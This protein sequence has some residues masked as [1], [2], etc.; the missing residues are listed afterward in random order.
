MWISTKEKLPDMC[1]FVLV[2]D[3][4]T[5]EC[6]FACLREEGEELR[7]YATEPEFAMDIWWNFEEFTHWSPVQDLPT[8][9]AEES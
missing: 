5:N 8:T 4:R 3:D 9:E 6:A 7:W 1:D 2:G